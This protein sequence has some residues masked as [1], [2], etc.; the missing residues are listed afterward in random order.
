MTDEVL[1]DQVD[2]YRRRASEYDVTAYGDV[3]AARERIARLVAQM[4]PRRRVL[5]IACGTGLWTEAL[6]GAADV[7]VAIDAAP[8]A[9]AIARDRVRSGN[10]TFEVADVFSWTTD[11]RFDAIFF[12]AWLSH[13][14]TSRFEEFWRLLR[15]LLTE[16]GR[17]LFID[18]HVDVREK[19]SYVPGAGEIVERRLRDGETYRIVK[20]FVDPRELQD[21]LRDL[22][23]DCRI[24]R[25]G[26]DWIRGE[27]RPVQ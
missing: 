7:V 19:E 4:S 22:G 8:E 16:D 17:V 9:V 1:A 26:D 12:S 21:R 6:A 27:A 14:P 24:H 10:V 3:A 13:V 5:E 25:D 23:W 2:Y 11:D 18:E 15:R 20:N